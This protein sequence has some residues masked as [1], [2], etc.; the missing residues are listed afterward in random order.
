MA[1]R[2]QVDIVSDDKSEKGFASLN[3]R[4]DA[5]R[6]SSTKLQSKF[7]G[8]Q[9]PIDK[10]SNVFKTF[11]GRG[12]LRSM[13]GDAS[14]LTSQFAKLTGGLADAGEGI[15]SLSGLAAD[16]TLGLTALAAAY[17]GALTAGTK[18][19]GQFARTGQIVANNAETYGVSPR[20]LQSFQ[21][22]AEASGIDP[23]AAGSALGA[24]GTT[25]H[26]V[27]YGH[28]PEAAVALADMHIN[29]SDLVGKNG[30][31]DTEKA[32]M[33]LSDRISKMRDPYT[34]AHAAD[35]FGVGGA[36]PLLRQGP[37]KLRRE[38][39]DYWGT[40]AGQTDDQLKR[41]DIF[42][43]TVTKLHQQWY[44][45]KKNIAGA[46]EPFLGW[47]VNV[48]SSAA[49]AV[50][51]GS[52]DTTL[53]GL[54]DRIEHRGE[55]SRQDQ[56]SPKG[57]VGVMQLMPDTARATAA[58]L[59]IRFDE[60][61]YRTDA[62]YNRYLGEALL[63]RLYRKYGGDQTL[64][65]EAYNAGEGIVDDW[66]AGTNRTHKN[67]SLLRLGDPRK[68]EISDLDFARRTPFAETRDYALRVA[69]FG[70]DGSSQA[71]REVDPQPITGSVDVTVN[72]NGAPPGTVTRTKSRGAVNP[73]TKIATSTAGI[74]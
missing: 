54:A 71:K 39:D 53:R 69:D 66:I 63:A 61:R 32:A 22:A 10:L 14:N 67:R 7:D 33:I 16:A 52:S 65:A 36:L 41:S 2:F 40:G 17:A 74:P 57:A 50:A 25:L 21:G 35:V 44:G 49:A 45:F 58:S 31:V 72:I 38:M 19:A 73:K 26:K 64:T 29:F 56:V 9:A 68:G 13:V 20:F 1:N 43:R 47:N 60:R 18:F 24:L 51:P 42:A 3:R 5:A 46:L 28:D 55:R 27:Q 12:D 48:A 6:R 62:A 15:T 4:M 11:N 34:Q 59:G 30:V 70:A 8:F 23:N 37:S